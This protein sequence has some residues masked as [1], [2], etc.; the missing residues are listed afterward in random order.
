ME[1][2]RNYFDKF[3]IPC[4]EVQYK[5]FKDYM[6]LLLEMNEYINLTAIKEP[7]EFILKHYVDSSIIYNSAEYGMAKTVLDLG[8]GGGFPGIPLAI[9]SPEKEFILVDSLNKRIKAVLEMAEEIG[10]KNVKVVHGRAEDLGRNPKY[11]DHFDL[12]VSRAVANL[13]VLCEYCLP[14]VKENGYF[15]AYKSSEI[16]EE[17][18]ESRRAIK[19]LKG[20]LSNIKTFEIAANSR[21]LIVIEKIARTPKPYP[22]QAGKPGRLPIKK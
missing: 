20:E 8:T 22:R 1:L 19:V 21:T 15:I 5:Q 6:E 4:S 16:S 11:R 7:K 2:L 17:V 10:L 13:D 14:F 9:L 3:G 12:C 18:Q